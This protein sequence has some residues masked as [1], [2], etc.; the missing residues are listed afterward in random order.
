MVSFI[1]S[2]LKKAVSF[3]KLRGGFAYSYLRLIA[4]KQFNPKIVSF[5]FDR[6][7]FVN[8][9]YTCLSWETTGAYK[10]KVEPNLGYYTANGFTVLDTNDLSNTITLKV[11]GILGKQRE[12]LHFTV[13]HLVINNS[14]P[15]KY[16]MP[17]SSINKRKIKV[18]I[19]ERNEQVMIPSFQMQYPM[20][21]LNLANP[22]INLGNEIEL[23]QMI[24]EKEKTMA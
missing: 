1:L 7:F 19:V 20:P 23:W 13:N 6:D 16:V 14:F 5:G 4:S 24:Q 2:I 9:S 21:T 17:E 22:I 15:V 18:S 12:T 3:F 10:V 8:D 11:Y